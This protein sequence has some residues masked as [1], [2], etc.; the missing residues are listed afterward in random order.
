[1]FGKTLCKRS[2]M[3][4][5]AIVGL[6]GSHAFA[7][8]VGTLHPLLTD[9]AKQVGGGDVEVV[10]LMPA[11]SD[12]HQFAPSGSQLAS[13][14]QTRI[15]LAMGKHLENY[16]PKIRDT[17]RQGQVIYEVGRSIPSVRIKEGS[18]FV[19]CPTHSRGAIDPHWWHGIKNMQRAASL[20][21]G[22]FGELDPDNKAAYAARAKDYNKRLDGLRVWAKTEISKVPRSARKLATAHAAWGY[23]C[24][25]FGFQSVPRQGLNNEQNASP[26]Y[27]QETVQLICK[28]EIRAVFPEQGANPRVLNA[29][30]K[31]TGVKVGA[32]LNASGS[33]HGKAGTFEGMMRHNVSTIVAALK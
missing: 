4:A 16:L 22:E 15:V 33:G 2:G 1:M 26:G 12:P 31:Q 18:L 10:S 24:K 23:F 8:K 5:L 21:A 9:L 28:H 25:E 27:L 19:C 17:L 6:L 32:E 3:M 11:G 13:L 7:L 30:A 29:I 20:L 14:S